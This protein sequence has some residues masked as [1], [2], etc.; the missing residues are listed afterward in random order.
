MDIIHILE[1][2]VLN[3]TLDINIEML[4]NGSFEEMQSALKKW[5][6]N[7]KKLEVINSMDSVLC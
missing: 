7:L 5:N 2:V 3:Q 1:C 6:D 4:T